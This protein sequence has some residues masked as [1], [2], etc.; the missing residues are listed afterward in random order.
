MGITHR[1]WAAVLLI[2]CFA[3]SCVTI[4]EERIKRME[5]MRRLG[6]AHYRE[7]NYTAALRA[8]LEAKKNYPDDPQ[9]QNDLGLTYMGKEKYELAVD[10]FK[11]AITLK[12]DYSHAKNNLGT[13]YL[14]QKK[15]D[16]AI[17][18]F[19]EAAEDLTYETP[20]FPLSNL[21]WA[22]YNKK[23]YNLSKQYYQ[24]ALKHSPKFTKALLGLART[25]KETGRIPEAISTV[26]KA[27]GYDPQL[28]HLYFDLGDL[29][30][31]SR[32]Y[33]KA[34]QAYSRVVTLVPDSPLAVEAEKQI[35]KLKRR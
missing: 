16:L 11:K 6:E 19:K 25:Y 33:E 31:L 13:A 10:R 4:Q 15:W 30:T 5:D 24:K 21:G 9:L 12:P 20:H 18:Y 7:G 32:D 1:S 35:V 3:A 28:P 34:L 29:Y 26:K 23:D 17:P 2:V 14:A 27:I 22:Y 8:L